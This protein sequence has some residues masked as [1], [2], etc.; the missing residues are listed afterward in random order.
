MWRLLLCINGYFKISNKLPDPYSSLSETVPSDTTKEANKIVEQSTQ[1]AS[2]KHG[3]ITYLKLTLIQQA[4]VAKYAVDNGNQVAI[5]RYSNE[6]CADI[7][8]ST[9]SMYMGI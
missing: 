7:K 3:R 8:E 2:T 1:N 6:F 9:L 5:R 4:Q